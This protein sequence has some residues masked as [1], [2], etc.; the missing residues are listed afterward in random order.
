VNR[1]KERANSAAPRK[2]D[3][4]RLCS[5]QLR[6]TPEI[7]FTNGNDDKKREREETAIVS[8]TIQSHC[9]FFVR[10]LCAEVNATIRGRLPWRLQRATSNENRPKRHLLSRADT[11]SSYNPPKND[12]EKKHTFKNGKEIQRGSSLAAAAFFFFLRVLSAW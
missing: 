3:E 5:T 12:A 8:M 2:R 1:K 4:D 6:A 7:R 10:R 9:N 11:R